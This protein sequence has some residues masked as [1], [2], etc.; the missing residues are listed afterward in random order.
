MKI[1]NPRI[2]FARLE[3]RGV[4]AERETGGGVCMGVCVCG[5]SGE[6]GGGLEGGGCLR[7]QDEVMCAN[8]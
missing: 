4:E 2:F 8:L 6:G 7:G 1:G 3:V 5:L